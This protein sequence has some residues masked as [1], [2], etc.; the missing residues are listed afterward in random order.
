MSKSDEVQEALLNERINKKRKQL[1][2]LKE[3]IRNFK[4]KNKE[5]ADKIIKKDYKRKTIQGVCSLALGAVLCVLNLKSIKGG[6]PFHIDDIK[7]YRELETTIDEDG[8]V[9]VMEGIYR[10]CGDL[11]TINKKIDLYHFPA[12]SHALTGETIQYVEKYSVEDLTA[13][14]IVDLLAKDK[15]DLKSLGEPEITSNIY[16]GDFNTRPF[17]HFTTIDQTDFIV[18]QETSNHNAVESIIFIYGTMCYGVLSYAG[19]RGLY[20]VCF[21]GSEAKVEIA[22]ELIEEYNQQIEKANRLEEKIAKL[23]RNLK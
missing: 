23:E 18:E 16:K 4:M 14:E 17:I 19:I 3:D 10:P 7:Y 8:N 15:L 1:E 2:E 6:Y 21:K 11:K 22:K 13:E 5:E 9:K 20:K 12:S